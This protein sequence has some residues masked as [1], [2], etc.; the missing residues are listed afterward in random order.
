MRNA[1]FTAITMFAIATLL[2]ANAPQYG[3]KDLPAETISLEAG[4]SWQWDN[5]PDAIRL[6]FHSDKPISFAIVPMEQAN[7]L[8]RSRQLLEETDAYQRSTCKG[9]RTLSAVREC[10]LDPNDNRAMTLLVKD[11]RKLG[12]VALRFE[13]QFSV[14]QCVANCQ[15]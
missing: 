13:Y 4:A 10:R 2:F 6:R 3:W 11:A 7:D 9:Q 5:L 15:P 14:W 12:L 1:A 8:A